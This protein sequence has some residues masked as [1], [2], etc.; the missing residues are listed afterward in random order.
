MRDLAELLQ[1]RLGEHEMTPIVCAHDLGRE[2]RQRLVRSHACFALEHLPRCFGCLKRG[3]ADGRIDVRCAQGEARCKP[4]DERVIGRDARI[5]QRRAPMVGAF[6]CI[7]RMDVGATMR[8]VR[9]RLRHRCG[10]RDGQHRRQALA[11]ALAQDLRRCA[12]SFLGRAER[13]D[14]HRAVAKPRG[15]AH[16]TRER[17]IARKRA[18]RRDDERRSALRG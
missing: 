13:I 12:Q 11:R 6:A 16:A 8:K 1:R 9:E 2:L 15:E 5:A 3:G 10:A 4:F 18:R 17:R 7:R 14:E